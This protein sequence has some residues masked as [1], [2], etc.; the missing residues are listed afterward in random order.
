MAIGSKWLALDLVGAA[1][2][3]LKFKISRY[4]NDPTYETPWSSRSDWDPIIKGRTL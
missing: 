3:T 4:V 2:A 1:V